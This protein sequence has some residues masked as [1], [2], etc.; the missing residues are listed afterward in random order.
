MIR[1][2]THVSAFLLFVLVRVLFKGLFGDVTIIGD[3]GNLEMIR[4][5]L[6]IINS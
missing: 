2:Y 6:R 3:D 4:R 1:S 5:H